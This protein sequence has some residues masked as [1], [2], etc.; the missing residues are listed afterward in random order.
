MPYIKKN[1]PTLVGKLKTLLA[2]GAYTRAELV[3]K[4]NHPNK[5]VVHSCLHWLRS[6]GQIEVVGVAANTR[7]PK[8][9][10]YMGV[11]TDE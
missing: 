11:E 6:K 1:K 2:E 7:G 5:N 9:N 10:V 8:E 3:E 4:L